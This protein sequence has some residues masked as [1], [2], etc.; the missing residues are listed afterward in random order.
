M[1]VATGE[2]I[3]DRI[4]FRELFESQ[5]VDIIQPDVGHIGGIWETRKLAATAETHYMLV[6]PHNVG[7]PVL[8]AASPPGRLHRPELQDPRALQRLRGRGHQEGRQG[9]PAGRRRLLR[10]VRR[11]RSRR[12]AGHGRGGRVPPAA[13]PLRPV[14]GRLGAAQAQG[15]AQ[16]DRPSSSSAGRAPAGARTSPSLRPP[17]RLSYGSTR[18]ASAAVTVR[19]TRATGPRGTSVIPLTPGHEWSGTV[20]AVGSGVP[21]P[22]S[23][24]RSWARASATARSATAATRA[25]RRCAPP[26][27]RRRAS[28]SP[29]P[30]RAR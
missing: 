24:A 29:A 18:A 17:A 26:G 14:G 1:P 6:A 23:A 4:E 27:T 10:A 20:E 9:R 13:G 25:R 8:T 19:C 15:R 7:G 22:S 11:A 3:H 30:W 28:R 5:A 16:R 21:E 12:R 2:R